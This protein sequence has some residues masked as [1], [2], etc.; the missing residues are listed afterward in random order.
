MKTFFDN[1]FKYIITA[2][3]LIWLAFNLVDMFTR[4]NGMSNN[5]KE[6]I[7]HSID[8]LILNEILQFSIETISK[9]SPASA[10]LFSP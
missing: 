6:R 10:V 3:I 1:N 7:I 4:T 9:D 8:F 5:D 2:I